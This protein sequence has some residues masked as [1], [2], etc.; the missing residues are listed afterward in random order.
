M[1]DPVAPPPLASL[2]A[3][4]P[5]KLRHEIKYVLPEPQLHQ[6]QSWIH[7]HPAAFYEPFPPRRVNNVYFDSYDLTA[8]FD[9]I[10]GQSVRDKVRLRWYGDVTGFERCTLEFKHRRNKYGWKD[11]FKMGLSLDMREVLWRE[12]RALVRA[13]LPGWARMVFDA[14][15]QPVIINSYQRSYFLSH[16]GSV[17][18]TLDT[19]QRFFEQRFKPRPNVLHRTEVSPAL[20]MEAKFSVDDQEVARQILAST[21]VRA[22]KNSKY[23]NGVMAMCDI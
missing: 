9:N 10:S 18:V 4:D 5:H 21:P 19:A 7:Q 13:E 16:D 1:T 23:V 8:C 22:G 12:L 20:I 17:R 14:S 3:P 15:P 11:S 6:V 2:A